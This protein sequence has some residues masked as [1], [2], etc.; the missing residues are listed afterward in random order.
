MEKVLEKVQEEQAVTK[1]KLDQHDA[2]NATMKDMLAQIL[3]KLSGSSSSQ[4]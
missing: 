1:Q 4:T 3:A 2:S